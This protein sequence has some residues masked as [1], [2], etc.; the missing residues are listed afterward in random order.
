MDI[1]NTLV[2]ELRRDKKKATILAVLLVVAVVI[3]LRLVMSGGPAP[4]KAVTRAPAAAKAAKAAKAD[5]QQAQASELIEA[6][7]AST[8]NQ[9]R[10]A[11]LKELD[12]MIDRDLFQPTTSVYGAAPSNQ[13]QKRSGMPPAMADLANRREQVETAAEVLKLQSTVVSD[14]PTAIINDQVL[15]AGDQIEGFTVLAI[16]PRSC[17]VEKDAIRLVLELR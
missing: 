17:I 13:T 10:D 4:A 9:E 16:S 8:A 7:D 1:K 15:K 12:R 14:I 11:Y 3:V 2:N 5:K 6:P